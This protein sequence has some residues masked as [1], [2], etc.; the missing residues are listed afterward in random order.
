MEWVEG[1]SEGRRGGSAEGALQEGW[2]PSLQRT[3]PAP[4][5]PRA[6]GPAS[7]AASCGTWKAVVGFG[8]WL[9]EERARGAVPARPGAALEDLEP[10]RMGP[11]SQAEKSQLGSRWLCRS[12][13]P[14]GPCSHAQARKLIRGWDFLFSKII[15]DFF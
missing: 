2:G 10:G 7:G 13:R 8:G 14:P 4:P 11:R 15:A 12:A 5:Q 6:E 9:G 1:A 3:A